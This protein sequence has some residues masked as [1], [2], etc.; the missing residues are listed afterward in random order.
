[1]HVEA[2]PC[3]LEDSGGGKAVA[4]CI[5]VIC[6]PPHGCR[7]RNLTERTQQRRERQPLLRDSINDIAR[8]QYVPGV[9]ERGFH[10]MLQYPVR[11]R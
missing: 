6:I 4:S 1:M 2:H 11:I 3:K 8:V 7:G 9:F 5:F 10:G